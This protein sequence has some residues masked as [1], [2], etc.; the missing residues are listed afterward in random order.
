MNFWSYL[1]YCQ[2][3]EAMKSTTVRYAI[4][5]PCD[6]KWND[7]QPEKQGRFCGSCEKSVVDFTNMSDFSIVSYLENHKHDKVCGRFTKP[8]LERVYQLKPTAPLPVV[9]LR[10]V[11]LGLALTTFSAVHTFAQSEPQE[12]VKIDSVVQVEPVIMGKIA[13]LPP[14][15]NHLSEKLVKGTITNQ[16]RSYQGIDVQLKNAKGHV[17]KTVQPDEKGN[18]E[19]ELNWKRDPAYIEISGVGFETAVRTF[20]SLNSLSGIRVELLEKEEFMIVGEVIQVD[21]E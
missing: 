18:F 19:I 4:Q 17:L 7:M 8:Q 1:L 16:L 21:P 2:K 3:K 5:D 11:V 14:P 13:V 9:D 20:S 15:V 10:A 6:K 12:P